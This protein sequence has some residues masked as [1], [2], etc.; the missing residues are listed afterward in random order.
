LE[1][2]H[3]AVEG[4]KCRV[5]LSQPICTDDPVKQATEQTAFL[6]LLAFAGVQVGA[7]QD[8]LHDWP[9]KQQVLVA[10]VDC[11][12]MP[13]VRLSQKHVGD[14]FWDRFNSR[15]GQTST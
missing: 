9:T 14:F 11:V 15:V 3:Y 10:V 2:D 7:L 12:H 5:T 8:Q 6:D 13:K 1:P 4:R